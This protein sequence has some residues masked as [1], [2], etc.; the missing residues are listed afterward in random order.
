MNVFFPLLLLPYLPL[1]CYQL[2]LFETALNEFLSPGFVI[3]VLKICLSSMLFICLFKLYTLLLM[4]YKLLYEA[5][6]P[7]AEYMS[8]GSKMNSHTC[9]C[10]LD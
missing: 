8:A 5:C 2:P 4:N 6:F 1:L 9:Q 3:G 7:L 10:R